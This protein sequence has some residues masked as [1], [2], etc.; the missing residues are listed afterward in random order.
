MPMPGRAARWAMGAIPLATRRP[1]IVRDG[2][3]ASVAARSSAERSRPFDRPPLGESLARRRVL[4]AVVDLPSAQMTARAALRRLRR[5]PPPS[6]PVVH[7]R[8]ERDRN[9]EK[10]PSAI[11]SHRRLSGLCT[12]GR[13]AFYDSTS[14][15]CAI[16]GTPR[17]PVLGWPRLS[18]PIRRGWILRPRRP[19]CS[20]PRSD[21][22]AC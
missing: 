10:A 20:R 19:G 2:D 9:T 11:N 16:I 7:A 1:G 3:A 17:P 5:S 8:I 13:I 14:T 6:M 21:S 12:S 18:G 15:C 22:G 4:G